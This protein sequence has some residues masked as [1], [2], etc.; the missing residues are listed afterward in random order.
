MAGRISIVSKRVLSDYWGTTTGYEID[1][2]RADGTVQRLRREAYD[3]G[4]AAAVLP[5]DAA[6]DTVVLVRQFRF[7]AHIAGGPDVLTEVV[8]GL[9]DDDSPEACI[10][11]EAMEEAG[12]TLSD[13]VPAFTIFVSPGSI[14]EKIHCFVGAYAGPVAGASGL[15][16]AHEGEDIEVVELGFDEAFGLIGRGDI[17]DAKTILLLQHLALGRRR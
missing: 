9:L 10:R 11:R 6:R 15:G 17:V 12:V 7:A 3:H 14:T 4:H 5:Y 8:A 2:T 13:V 16:L 1:Y